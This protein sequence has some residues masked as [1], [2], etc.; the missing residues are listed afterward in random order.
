MIQFTDLTKRFG[1]VTALNGVATHLRGGRVV[2]LMG[3]NASGK[4]TLLKCLLGIVQPTSGTVQVL[5]QPIRGQW[6]YRQAIGYMP[7]LNH[8]PE[9]LTTAQLFEMM[10]TV[11]PVPP[12]TVLDYELYEAYNLDYWRDRRLGTLSGGTRQKINAAL[13]FLFAPRI[14]VLD[15]PSVGLDPVAVEVLKAKI[16]RFRAAERLVLLTSHQFPEAE[17][18]GEDLLYIRDGQVQL[19]LPIAD[20]LAR[21]DRPT[22]G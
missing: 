15:E 6:A 10:R 1:A 2:V 4:S 3:P 9:N 18:V 14:V 7:Q 8:L 19:D 21:A 16:R 17:E 22:L 20:L 12:G 5:G 11:R 13:T